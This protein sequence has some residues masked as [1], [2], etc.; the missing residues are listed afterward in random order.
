MATA[1]KALPSWATVGARVLI[2]NGNYGRDRK[3]LEAKITRVTKASVFAKT[4]KGSERR[5]VDMGYTREEDRLKEYGHST[6]WYP[7]TYLWNPEAENVKAAYAKAKA[8]GYEERLAADAEALAKL[9]RQGGA[10]ASDVAKHINILRARITEYEVSR[11]GNRKD[12]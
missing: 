3:F 12:Q 5:F 2:E 11:S 8:R 4:E 9:M 7:G 10:D 6:G 1:T